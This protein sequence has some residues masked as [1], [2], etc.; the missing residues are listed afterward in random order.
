MTCNIYCQIDIV[1]RD[2]FK[3]AHQLAT[4]QLDFQMPERFELTYVRLVNTVES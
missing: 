4:I 1:I 2:A 3:R